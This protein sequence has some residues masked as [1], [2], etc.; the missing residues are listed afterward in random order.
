MWEEGKG[1]GGVDRSSI[2]IAHTIWPVAQ[3]SG[4][5]SLINSTARS[6]LHNSTGAT[7]WLGLWR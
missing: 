5:V 1:R 3:M 4:G 7:W 6:E 2:R